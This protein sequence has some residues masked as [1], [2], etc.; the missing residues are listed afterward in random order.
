MRARAS[1]PRTL[2]VSPSAL[3]LLALGLLLG[4]IWI[5]IRNAE[6]RF[7]QEQPPSTIPLPPALRAP[8][9]PASPFPNPL[10]HFQSKSSQPRRPRIAFAI[11]ITRDGFFLDGA[12]V[13]AYSI[14]RHSSQS[15]Y[16]ISLIAFVHPN[17]TTS[18][19]GLKNLGFHVI[20]VPIPINVSAIQF[21]FLRE[22]INK[23]GCCGSSELIKLTSYRLLQYDKV[24]HLDADVIVL[25]PLDSLLTQRRDLSL[26]Y[27]TDP[28]MATFKKKIEHMP[29]QGGFL[30]ITPSINDYR[31]IINTEVG[32]Y[33]YIYKGNISDVCVYY[34]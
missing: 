34:R 11:T 8:S 10:I 2:R 18:R 28:N 1:G 14:L 21:D 17:V 32:I 33:I 7:H 27:T 5:Y 25:N 29:V 4:A 24:V 30:V 15:P 12:A 26:V 9:S 13:L 23:N 20:E 16:S 19:P 22:K 6:T 31:A 3:P